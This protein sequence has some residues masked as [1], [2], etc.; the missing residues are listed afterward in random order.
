M[1]SLIECRKRSAFN[2]TR[3]SLLRVNS[4]EELHRKLIYRYFLLKDLIQQ[5]ECIKFL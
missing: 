3:C 5:M 2:R 4:C 1:H